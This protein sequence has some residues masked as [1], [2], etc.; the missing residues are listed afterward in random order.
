MLD[1]LL[2]GKE[3]LQEMVISQSANMDS[4]IKRILL[5]DVCWIPSMLARA[6]C[7]M[8]RSTRPMV[9]SLPYL[10][11]LAWM[12]ARFLAVWR[13]TLPSKGFGMEMQYGSRSNT[14]HQ[15]PGGRDF[16]DLRLFPLL[17]PS[18]SKS[19]Q[20]QS[21]QSATGPCL[22][23]HSPKH[24]TGWPI[25]GLKNWWPSGQILGFL[26]LTM[27]HPQ[28]DWKVTVKMRPQSLM[29]KRWTLRR[30]REKTWKPARKTAKGLVSRI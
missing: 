30:S 8:Q 23:T 15:P 13:S 29:F 10:A 16:V 3:S 9:S 2:E 5:D 1:S 14:S 28:Q 24:A 4:P 20:H 26:C 6:S 27:S 25:Q 7:L 22:G 19:H 17:P 18:Y 11:T 12:R 21:P